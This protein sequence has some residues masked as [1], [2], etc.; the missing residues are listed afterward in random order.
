MCLLIFCQ[1]LDAGSRSGAGRDKMQRKY[2]EG[3]KGEKVTVQLRQQRGGCVSQLRQLVDGRV[4]LEVWREEFG[5]TGVDETVR[6]SDGDVGH[7]G[8]ISNFCGNDK[9][10]T[11]VLVTEEQLLLQVSGLRGR[12]Q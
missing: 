10:D 1:C 8:D 4:E 6:L 2:I 5:R 7:A 3:E 12:L 9:N 11:F